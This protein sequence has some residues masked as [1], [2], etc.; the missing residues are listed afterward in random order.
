MNNRNKKRTA[1]LSQKDF[2]NILEIPTNDNILNLNS[3]NTEINTN[4][5][6]LTINQINISNNEL[7]ANNT[8]H[9]FLQKP[10]LLTIHDCNDNEHYVKDSNVAELASSEGVVEGEQQLRSVIEFELNQQVTNKN[11][12]NCSQ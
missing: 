6:H 5:N 4:K 11:V 8:R 10:Q 2:K 9:S 7:N 12:L 3:K 1:L